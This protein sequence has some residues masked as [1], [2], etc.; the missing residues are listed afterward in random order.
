[1]ILSSVTSNANVALASEKFFFSVTDKKLA[2]QLDTIQGQMVIC[3]IAK[4][5]GFFSGMVIRNIWS[6][7]LS[8]NNLQ[9]T[10]IPLFIVLTKK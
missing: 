1:M 5:T 10:S 9:Q 2:M 3:T 7:A 8:A 6:T 4:K